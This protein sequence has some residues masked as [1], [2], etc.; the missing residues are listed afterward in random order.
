MADINLGELATTTLR[1]RSKELADNISNHN[2][3]W[4]RLNQKGNIRTASGGRTI[5]EELMYAENSTVAWMSG[6]DNL[7]TTPTD[8]IDAAEYSWKQLAGTIPM[9]GLEQIQNAGESAAINWLSSKI[10]NLEIS[11]KNTAATSVY[12]DG[13]GSSGKDLA[14][15]ALIVDD[16]GQST[17]GGINSATYSWWRNQ[18]SASATTSSGNV[19][20]RMNSMWISLVRG[21]DKPDLITAPSTLYVDYL[22]SLQSIQRVTSSEMA[23]AGFT[24]LKYMQADFVYDD[25]CT[26]NRMFFLNTD[27]LFLRPAAGR[28]FEVGERRSSI[29]QDSFV[30]PVFWAGA[31]TCS[32]RAL[33]GV[34]IDSGS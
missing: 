18:F 26:A 22:E 27:Y 29:N 11:M 31:M 28:Q 9:S 7:N 24:S 5:V 12:A 19:Q 15:L 3:T 13:T 8:T 34:I 10:R 2:A 16:D 20:N 14:G 25:Q 6:Y 1:L 17:V 23:S 33:Q 21:A 4:R 32:N 30:I